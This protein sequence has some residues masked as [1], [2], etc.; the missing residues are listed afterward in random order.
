MRPPSPPPVF[1]RHHVESWGNVSSLSSFRDLRKN[2][3]DMADEIR[4]ISYVR[5]STCKAS[6]GME[7]FHAHAPARTTMP[8]TVQSPCQTPRA[9]H[10]RICANPDT[11]QR[12]LQANRDPGS[13][14]KAILMTKPSLHH[15]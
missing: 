15:R 13:G 6:G 9:G 14:L 11:S 4:H 2:P 3:Q 12:L 10:C 7:L 1:L 5:A 8:H